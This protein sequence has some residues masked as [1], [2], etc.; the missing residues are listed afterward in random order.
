MS[1]AIQSPD[2][3]AKVPTQDE[4]TRAWLKNHG[5]D[6]AKQFCWWDDPDTNCRHFTQ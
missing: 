4:T 5:V 1:E 6:L 3:R 2:E